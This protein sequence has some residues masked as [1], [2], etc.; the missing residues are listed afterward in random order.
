MLIFNFANLLIFPRP[1][2]YDCPCG[3]HLWQS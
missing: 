1:S 3:S 2:C